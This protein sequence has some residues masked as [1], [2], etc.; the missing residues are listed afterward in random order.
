VTLAFGIS[1]PITSSAST[2]AALL[3]EL[4][5]ETVAAEE[6]GLDLVMIPEHHQGPPVS[7]SSPLTLAA[8]LAQA[9][10]RIRLATGILILPPHHPVHLAEQVTMLDH[11][12]R[13]RF[14]LGV[15][16]GYQDGDLLPF[17]VAMEDRVAVMEEMMLALTRLLTSDEAAFQGKHLSF[18][19]TK[20][21]PRPL[22]TPSP[23]VWL[24]SWSRT[25]VRRAAR[26]ADGWIADPVRTLGEV[27]EMAIHYREALRE[28]GRTGATILMREAWV[29]TDKE[30]AALNFK[31]VID[32]VF[33]Y[34]RR[35]GAYEGPAQ[36]FEQLAADRF[37]FG[38]AA[39]CVAQAIAAADAT[40]ADCVVLQLRHPHGP[41]HE[42]TVERIHALGVELQRIRAPEGTG[43]A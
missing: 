13:G 14:V 27:V 38:D 33:K 16:A 31:P 15:G 4:I 2:V 12:S 24:G 3:D 25:G 43:A 42:E 20:L 29:D 9:T 18:P 23:A 1:L 11:L 26:M 10:H 22:T 32:P 35:K 17:G 28:V 41:T 7:F 8:A 6:A 40:G 30:T 21:R 36:D 5:E 37:I 19:A 39:S 34:Y